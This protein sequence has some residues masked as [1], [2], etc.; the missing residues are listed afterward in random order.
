MGQ[1]SQNVVGALAAHARR[2]A[3]LR[4]RA[5]CPV[6][7]PEILHAQ[8]NECL[9]AS[10]HPYSAIWLAVHAMGGSVKAVLSRPPDALTKVSS[11]GW[12][13]A[14]ATVCSR[15]PIISRVR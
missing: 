7:E 12:V 2:V 8:I 6:P 1:R 11:A 5:L 10:R 14:T 9:S 4:G 3:D 13:G 15:S